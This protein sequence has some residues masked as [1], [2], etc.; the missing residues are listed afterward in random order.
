MRR[1]RCEPRGPK[2]RVVAGTAGSSALS[3]PA[4]PF[5]GRLVPHVSRLVSGRVREGVLGSSLTTFS[6]GGPVAALVSV[7][8][9]EELSAVLGLL[10]GERQPVR[11]IGNGSN[12]LVAD[13]GLDE[14]VVS[15]GAGFRSVTAEAPGVL[16]VGGAASLMKLA[17][18][19]SDEGLSGLEFAAGIPASVGGAAFMNAGAH[20]SEV[21]ERLERVEGVTRDGVLRVWAKAELPWRYRHSGLPAGVVVTSVT[22][23]LQEG[24][25]AAISARCS[26]HLAERRARQPL[27]MPSAGSVFK[28]PSPEKP[29]GMLIEAAG[30]KGYRIGGAMVSGLHANWIV[31]PERKATASDIVLLMQ[32]CQRRVSESCGILLEPEV[33]LWGNA[34]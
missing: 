18:K 21:C 17:R 1:V 15:L 32:E 4:R 23:R 2:G 12:I 27:S 29:A 11:I 20:G 14:W 3:D 5:D 25:R 30:L 28:N 9:S 8:S 31:N 7:E 26:E 24:D 33:R 16:R 22:F 6:V 13:S 10:H 19:V 34:L